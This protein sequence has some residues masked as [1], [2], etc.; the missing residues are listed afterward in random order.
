MTREQI[1]L[2]IYENI[3]L[4]VKATRGKHKFVPPFTSHHA[5][6]NVIEHLT[7]QLYQNF[8]FKVKT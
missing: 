5:R 1:K 4:E 7:E 8:K 2:F 6:E 3:P